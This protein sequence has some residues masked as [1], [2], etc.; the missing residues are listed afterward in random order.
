MLTRKETLE[1]SCDLCCHFGCYGAE[2][3]IISHVINDISSHMTKTIFLE[4]SHTEENNCKNVPGLTDYEATICKFSLKFLQHLQYSAPSDYCFSPQ[5]ATGSTENKG[6]LNVFCESDSQKS[7][8]CSYSPQ[9]AVAESIILKFLKS[10]SYEVQKCGLEIIKSCLL[11]KQ[12]TALQNEDTEDFPY[13]TSQWDSFLTNYEVDYL[14]DVVKW[15]SKIYEELIAM[16]T[17][18]ELYHECLTEVFHF[19]Y[20][21]HLSL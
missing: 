14:F 18:K 20:S 21:A 12:V 9:M 2:N 3:D 11:Q 4:I 10:S 7:D 8:I 1:I 6:D 19:P 5:I 13:E 17:E 16:V 15:S